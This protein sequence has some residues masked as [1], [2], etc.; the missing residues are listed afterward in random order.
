MEVEVESKLN[1]VSSWWV[2]QMGI[3]DELKICLDRSGSEYDEGAG[4]DF[5]AMR[6]KAIFMAV[7]QTY[8]KHGDAED[9]WHIGANKG[10][11]QSGD[12]D[13]QK[14]QSVHLA[15]CETK[16]RERQ[17]ESGR[18]RLWALPWNDPGDRKLKDGQKENDDHQA[19]VGRCWPLREVY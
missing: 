2:A 6:G 10:L 8:Q 19:V 9:K 1:D 14:P 3:A 18:K 5:N 11:T 13:R 16:E 4:E 17:I 7:P 15:F 12:H